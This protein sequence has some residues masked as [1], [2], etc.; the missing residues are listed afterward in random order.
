MTLDYSVKGQ[1]TID[2]VDYVEK[3]IEEFNHNITSKSRV[4]TPA[5][6]KIFTV[7]A[8]PLLDKEKAEEFHTFVAKA[9][10]VAKRARPDAQ[11]AVAF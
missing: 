10:F 8:S 2:M 4:H 6:E 11:V 3:M 1:V 9:L 5:T 7:N